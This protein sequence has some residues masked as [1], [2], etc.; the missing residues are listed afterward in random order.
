MRYK[1]PLDIYGK[2]NNKQFFTSVYD[3]EIAKDY[4]KNA[5]L[6]EKFSEK[7]YDK[8][9]NKVI[10]LNI[11]PAKRYYNNTYGFYDDLPKINQ[12]AYML[13]SFNNMKIGDYSWNHHNKVLKLL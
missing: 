9:K 2:I 1:F 11:P 12:Y 4:F 10:L 13:T 3:S 6:L 8:F 5:K 7:I